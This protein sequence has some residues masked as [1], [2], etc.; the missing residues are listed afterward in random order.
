[1][2][3]HEF[4]VK[5]ATHTLPAHGGPIVS[6]CNVLVTQPHVFKVFEIE[7]IPD[8]GPVGI[9]R[10]YNGRESEVSLNAVKHNY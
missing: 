4:G 9:C 7:S 1:M 8:V 2:S 10:F 6:V 3:E 5:G